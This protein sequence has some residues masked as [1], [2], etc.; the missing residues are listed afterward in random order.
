MLA[1]TF[2]IHLFYIAQSTTSTVVYKSQIQIAKH[3][4]IYIEHIYKDFHMIVELCKKVLD[5]FEITAKWAWWRFQYIKVDI[6]CSCFR[7]EF[8]YIYVYI[9][10]QNLIT[11]LQ[12]IAYWIAT[13][14]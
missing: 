9:T 3:T 11:N 2:V 8:I 5:G 7:K 12:N 6:D 14:K 4:Y 13:N 10:K 1:R